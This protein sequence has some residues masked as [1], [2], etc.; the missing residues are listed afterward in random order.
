MSSLMFGVPYAFFGKVLFLNIHMM[1]RQEI[2][3]GLANRVREKQ[4]NEMLQ[5]EEFIDQ[6]GHTR[7]EGRKLQWKAKSWEAKSLLDQN[8]F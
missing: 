5:Q 1:S 8:A 7:A 3:I 2:G 6:I 4:F